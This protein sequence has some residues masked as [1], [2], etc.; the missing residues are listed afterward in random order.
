MRQGVF[1][2]FHGHGE[3][4]KADRNSACHPIRQSNT[5][6]NF[7]SFPC[8]PWTKI[9]SDCRSTEKST[10]FFRFMYYQIRSCNKITFTLCCNTVL[11]MEK[12]FLSP[13]WGCVFGWVFYPGLRFG[14]ATALALG[15]GLST[16]SRLFCQCSFL[17][18]TKV[19]GIKAPKAR[20][21]TARGKPGR[22]ARAAP[23]RHSTKIQAL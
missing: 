10:A 1:I 7:P 23:G 6:T 22:Q 5:S 8:I 16:A 19:C 4:N 18:G 15:Y 14:L 21:N 2:H 12:H 17:P 13:R 11:F 3:N 20:K 9:V